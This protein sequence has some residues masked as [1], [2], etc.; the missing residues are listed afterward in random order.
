ICSVRRFWPTRGTRSGVPRMRLMERMERCSSKFSLASWPNPRVPSRRKVTMEG[1][2]FWPSWL[3]ITSAW[4]YWKL[5]TTELLVPKSMP[6]YA[7][8]RASVVSYQLSVVSRF[9]IQHPGTRHQHSPCPLLRPASALPLGPLVPTLCVGTCFPTLCVGDQSVAVSLGS[10]PGRG[11]SGPA[12]PRRAWE[13]EELLGDDD[14][15]PAQDELRLL[16]G[17]AALALLGHAEGVHA[18][19]AAAA[20]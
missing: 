17:V 10:R 16:A 20:D 9:R 12:F 13:R 8:P 6:M 2:H 14:L 19:H 15:G 5:A 11:A 18:V 4:P 1:V 7:I 3:G